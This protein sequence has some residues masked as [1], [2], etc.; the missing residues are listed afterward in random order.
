MPVIPT[1]PGVYIEELPS[2]VRTIAGVS[3]STTAFIGRAERGPVNVPVLINSYAEFDR[4]FGGLWTESY[5]GYSVRDF[6]LNGGKKAIIVRLYHATAGEG[7]GEAPATRA[8]LVLD[9]LSLLAASPGSWGND[10]QALVDHDTADPDDDALFNLTLRYRVGDITVASESFRNVSGDAASPR[11]VARVLHNESSLVNVNG[12]DPNDPASAVDIARPGETAEWVV[13]AD[14]AHVEDGD[15]LDDDDFI[16]DGLQGRKEG[17]Y[18]LENTDIFNLLV[19]PP[20]T[21]TQDVDPEVWEAA[22]AYCELRRA[23]LI[24]DPPSTWRT[25]ANATAADTGVDSLP[26]TSYAAVFF[27]RILQRDTLRDDQWG[28]FTASGAIAGVFARTDAQRGVWKA[29][30]GLDAT[31]V[32]VPQ[33]AVPLSDGENGDLNPLGIN[34]LRALPAAGRVVW[35]ARTRRGADRLA[36]QWKYIPIRRLALFIE[37]SLYRGTQWVVFEPNDEP[38]WAQIRLNVGAF[39]HTLFRQGA[40]QGTSPKQAYFVKCDSETTPQADIDRGIV[41]IIVGFAPLKP[42][43]FV[44]IQIQQITGELE[45]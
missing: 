30:A 32:N 26:A 33:L 1:Y 35:G 25:V 22:A 11:Y 23:F 12:F 43:E 31:L 5:L 39:M 2:D 34:A 42:A 20:Y 28:T 16:G 41:N 24:I 29:P 19:I 10:L 15:A 21:D 14:D 6:Y 40:F 13:V 4:T 38:L 8:P 37:E 27:P 18:A 7:E 36:D 3:T 45:V 9:D 44:I 17:L